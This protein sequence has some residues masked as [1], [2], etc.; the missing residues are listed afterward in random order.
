MKGPASAGRARPRAEVR[1]NVPIWNAYT[2]PKFHEG[3]LIEYE[4]ELADLKW[5]CC[6][7]VQIVSI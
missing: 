4:T 2:V 5:L 3:N 1:G 7:P 6:L